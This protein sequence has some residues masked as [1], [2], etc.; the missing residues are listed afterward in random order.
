MHH[1]D[2]NGIFPN[3]TVDGP[4]DCLPP[5]PVRETQAEEVAVVV[6]WVAEWDLHH[7]SRGNGAE[8]V[9]VGWG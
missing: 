7:R 3:E 8:E 5:A 9:I 1:W 2:E 4:Q 6:E